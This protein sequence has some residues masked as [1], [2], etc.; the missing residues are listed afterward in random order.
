MINDSNAKAIA[1]MKENDLAYSDQSSLT[2]TD[3]RFANGGHYGVEIPVINSL[4]V[5]ESTV[6]A[7]QKFEINVTRFNETHGSFLL[8]DGELIEML[9]VCR[10]LG[11]GM[12]VGL[13]PRPEYDIKGSFY[14]S[15]FGLEMGRRNN[16]L[17]AIRQCVDEAI[18]LAELGCRGIT[19]YDEGVLRILKMMREQGALPHEMR[20]KTSTHMMCANPFIA[21]IFHENGA[22]SV[23]TAHDLGLPVIQEMRRLVPNLLLDIPTDVYKTKG[24]FIRFNELAE[25]IQIASPVMLKMGASA[26]GHPYDN[27]ADNVATKRVERVAIGLEILEKQNHGFKLIGQ[28]DPLCC[29]PVAPH[30]FSFSSSSHKLARTV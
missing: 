21:K 4:K 11:Y 29:H 7:I 27:V 24:G 9:T 23:T 3:H 10:E 6:S 8:S 26:Q 16:N 5:L 18:R 14:R 15:E 13:G 19:V 22:D 12:V 17:A 30:E 1:W 28:N 20:F 2:K 25:L